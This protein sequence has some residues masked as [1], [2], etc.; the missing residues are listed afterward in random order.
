MPKPCNMHLAIVLRAREQAT[1]FLGVSGHNNAPVCGA[2]VWVDKVIIAASMLLVFGIASS[3]IVFAGNLCMG[4][5]RLR[6]FNRLPPPVLQK[7]PL[8]APRQTCW[9]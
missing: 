6:S 8:K 3:G 5:V 1:G 2:G 7:E 9:W 4:R